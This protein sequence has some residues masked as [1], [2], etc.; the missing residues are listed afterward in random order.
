VLRLAAQLAR[1]ELSADSAEGE[2][3]AG[4]KARIGHVLRELERAK[5]AAFASLEL[6]R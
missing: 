6:A 5:R 3:L 1:L 4:I 2:Q